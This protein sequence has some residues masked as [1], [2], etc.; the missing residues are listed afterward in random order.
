MSAHGSPKCSDSL[1]AAA[2]ASSRPWAL[3]DRMRTVARD[4]AFCSG[5]CAQPEP[6]AG[7]EQGLVCLVPQHD[8]EL[9]AQLPHAMSLG[10]GVGSKQLTVDSK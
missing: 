9:A 6:V 8:G 4:G 7:G 5:R 2:R 3:H 10:N 1:E